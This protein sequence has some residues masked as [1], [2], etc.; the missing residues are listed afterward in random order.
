MNEELREVA[1]WA[2]GIILVSCG[3]ERWSRIVG[4]ASLAVWFFIYF[5][6]RL[7]F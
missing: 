1:Y 3:R 4:W 5:L 7:L 2:V 6:H